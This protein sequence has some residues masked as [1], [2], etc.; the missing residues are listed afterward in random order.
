MRLGL[1]IVSI[2]LLLSGCTQGKSPFAA[3][4]TR[5]Q[6]LSGEWTGKP[7]DEVKPKGEAF[8]SE[9]LGGYSIKLNQDRSF[10]LDWRGLTKEGTWAVNGDQVKLTVTKVFDKTREQASAEKLTEDLKLFDDSTTLK[11][12]KDDKSITLPGTSPGSQTV[13]FQKSPK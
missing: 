11:L 4:P 9:Q 5:E 2:S 13:V 7:V 1:W 10:S 6:T 12:S 3:K 8:L